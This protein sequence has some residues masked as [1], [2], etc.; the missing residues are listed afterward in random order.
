MAAPVLIKEIPSQSVNERAAY[1][2][3]DLTDYIKT[4]DGEEVFFEA[5]LANGAC[6][7]KGMICTADGLVTGIPGKNTR[8][9]YDIVIHASNDAGEIKVNFMFSIQPGFADRDTQ[10]YTNEL[11]EQIWR[12]LEQSLPAPELNDLLERAVT[13]LDIHYLLERWATLTIY[14]AYDLNAPGEK[15]LLMLEG[16]SEHYQI[17]DRG[18]C[19]V[20]CP[21]D[22]FS[23]ERTLADAIRTAEAVA[24]EV[25]KRQWPVELIGFEKLTRAAWVEI[26][27]LGDKFSKKLE[28]IN[29]HPSLSDIA[30]YGKQAD[31]KLMRSG[32]DN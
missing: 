10:E 19:L 2:P 17:Y 21:K 29:Y 3:F 9:N 24:R 26:M 13:P 20:A 6:L 27:H 22:L 5:D 1:G 31:V 16:A 12:A 28:V 18:C 14:N 32:L 15:S 25:Y 23:H 4:P 8:G 7:P 30:L 11:K